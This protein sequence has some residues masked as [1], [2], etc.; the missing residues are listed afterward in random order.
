MANKYAQR[1]PFV[2]LNNKVIGGRMYYASIR[3][4]GWMPKIWFSQTKVYKGP[5]Q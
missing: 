4:E 3:L 2:I 1:M 5:K